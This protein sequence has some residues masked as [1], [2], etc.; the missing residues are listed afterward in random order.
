MIRVGGSL[1]GRRGN[2]C[3]F[4]PRRAPILHMQGIRG[5]VD[6]GRGAGSLLLEYKDKVAS[7]EL[8]YSDDQFKV[9]RYLSRL[10]DYMET[11]PR[12]V[13]HEPEPEPEAE[14]E[15]EPEKEGE[16]EDSHAPPFSEETVKGATEKQP[17]IREVAA[18]Q[19]VPMVKGLY[20]HGGVVVGKT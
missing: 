13:I 11:T 10:S 12:P 7:D 19:V 14:R 3:A 4:L 8:E 15:R 20:I 18:E 1:L 16:K 6:S 2:M 17:A 9:L 5:I